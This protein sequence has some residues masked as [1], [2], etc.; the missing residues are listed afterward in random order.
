MSSIAEGYTQIAPNGSIEFS[1]ISP[2]N[3]I[4]HGTRKRGR[5][6]NNNNNRGVAYISPI[7][8]P[9]FSNTQPTAP[10]PRRRNAP[11]SLQTRR[12]RESYYPSEKIAHLNNKILE[13]YQKEIVVRLKE[14]NK[15]KK[16]DADFNT[17]YDLIDYLEK[18]LETFK[19]FMRH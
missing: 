14:I 19:P 15:D 1:Q 3:R 4:I 11:P 8:Q 13:I 9:N 10:S 6:S 18:S 5:Y 2:R 7:N 17:V 16:T 12:R